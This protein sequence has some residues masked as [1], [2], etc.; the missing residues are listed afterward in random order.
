MKK[1]KDNK[2]R[3]KKEREKNKRKSIYF[4]VTFVLSFKVYPNI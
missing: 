3:R 4:L 1:V 2:D